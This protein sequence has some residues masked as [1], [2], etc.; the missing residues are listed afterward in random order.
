MI[1]FL[2]KGIIRDKSRSLL[3]AVVVSIG[4]ALTVLMICWMKGVMGESLTMSANF[5]MGHLKV[6]TRAYLNDAD[7][8]PNDLAIIGSDTLIESLQREYPAVDWNN[9][10]R[11][12]GLVD[13]PDKDG[14]TKAQGPVAGWGIDLLNQASEE[15]E[16]FNLE[17]A[18]KSGT[19]PSKPGEALIADDFAKK[20]NIKTGE[21]FTLFGTSMEGSMAFMNFKVSGTILF[22]TPALDRG[23]V[24]VDI[25]DIRRALGMENATGEILGFFKNGV[26]NAEEATRIK[27]DFNQRYEKSDDEFSPA[28]IRLSDQGGMSDYMEYAGKMGG[29]LVTVF[30]LAMSIVL[31][32][33]GLLGGL[34]RYSEF[35]LRLAMGEEKKHIYK[36]L[37]YEG[38]LIGSIGSVIGTGVGL[39]IAYYLQEVGFDV[40]GMMKNSTLLMPSVLKA[41]VTPQAFYIGFIPGVF[42]MVLGNALSGIGIYKRKTAQLFKELE[43]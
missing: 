4:V 42:S 23:A 16:R 41:E 37:I 15:R 25:A 6:A 18:L 3:P 22:G 7:Q 39:G 30:V 24:I 20:F 36:S 32:N 40:S 5:G 2:F 1:R 8:I 28:M 43:N 19:I 14:E 31:W 12:G 27:A 10:I 35:G 26:Y 9:R 34:R 11:F 21:E 33:A 29:I 17:S 38:I 13:F